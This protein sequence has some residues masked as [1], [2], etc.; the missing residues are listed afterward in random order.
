VEVAPNR[1]LDLV[2]QAKRFFPGMGRKAGTYQSWSRTQNG[3]LIA[4]AAAN[5]GRTPGMLLYNT[6]HPPF[7]AA[8]ASTSV[9]GGCCSN[10][11]TCSRQS[12][13]PNRPPN[14]ESPMAVS[15]TFDQTAMCTLNRP[16]PLQIAASTMPLEC[17][18]CPNA[19]T[20]RQA[21]SQ[22]PTW[23]AQ[24]IAAAGGAFDDVSDAQPSIHENSTETDAHLLP[25][26]SIVL[27]MGHD[28][29]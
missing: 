1:W 8:Q 23:A 16:T 5:G 22:M 12:W 18:F 29:K 26:F 17:L 20:M 4:W 19:P 11:K 10:P 13:P 7:G 6:E 21:T 25:V 27:G 3:N 28:E 2:L 14:A 15:V 9:F 24:L